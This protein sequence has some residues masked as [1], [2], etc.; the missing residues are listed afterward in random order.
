MLSLLL[1]HSQGYPL[2]SNAPPAGPHPHALDQFL[3]AHPKAL[4]FVQMPKPI[5]TS[6]A[7]ESFF[8]VSA[9]TF[10]NADG[11][12]RS[13]RYRVLPV[14]GNAYLERLR[15]SFLRI[16]PSARPYR[17]RRWGEGVR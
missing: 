8:A 7:H 15:I 10:T 6:F 16:P 9:F 4:A 3:G 12:R 14:A 5:P 11:V 1:C 13:G 17:G 2:C